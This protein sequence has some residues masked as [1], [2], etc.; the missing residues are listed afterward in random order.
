MKMLHYDKVDIS[1]EIDV[2]KTSKPRECDI[3]HYRYFFIWKCLSFNK[4]SAMDH[5]V[6]EP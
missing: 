3:C 5:S 6:F 2:N 4:M 1:E